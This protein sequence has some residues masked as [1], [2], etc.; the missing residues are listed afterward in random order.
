MDNKITKFKTSETEGIFI[1]F[2]GIFTSFKDIGVNSLHYDCSDGFLVGV[3]E[4]SNY[5]EIELPNKNYILL[6]LVGEILDA[7]YGVGIA[8]DVVGDVK[9]SKGVM[10]KL[11]ES[12]KLVDVNGLIDK[13][14]LILLYNE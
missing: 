1:S 10:I 7:P 14:V 8:T 12:F 9:D 5:F 13:N 6:G 4:E 11:L 2:K 3:D